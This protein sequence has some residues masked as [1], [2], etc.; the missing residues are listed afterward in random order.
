[1]TPLDVELRLR[2]GIETPIRSA[3]QVTLEE[4]DGDEVVVRISA[5]P[6]NPADGPQLASEVLHAIAPLVRGGG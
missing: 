3:P 1:M 4:V 6:Q 2:E 5:A